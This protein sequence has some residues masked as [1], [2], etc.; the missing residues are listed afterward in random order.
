[1]QSP[2][3]NSS[4]PAATPRKKIAPNDAILCRLQRGQLLSLDA[5][6][7]GGLIILKTFYVDFAGPGAAVGGEF[8]RHCTAVYAIGQVQLQIP[9]NR[10]DQ[11]QVLLHRIA[12]A[13]SLA[14]IANIPGTLQRSCRIVE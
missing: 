4:H 8:D 7:W 14:K 3:L 1:M 5:A 13:S 9:S 12:Q 11:E 6:S 2:V 10:A